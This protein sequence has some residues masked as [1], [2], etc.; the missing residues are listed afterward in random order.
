MGERDHARAR[1]EG[2]LDASDQLLRRPRRNWHWNTSDY[3]GLTP[4]AKLPALIVR[5]MVVIG[6]EDLVSGL[7]VDSVGR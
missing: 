1:R 5:G 3:Q 4:R 6:D 7:E 2:F